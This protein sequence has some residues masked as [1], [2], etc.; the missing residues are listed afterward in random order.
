MNPLGPVEPD[1]IDTMVPPKIMRLTQ[2]MHNLI[3]IRYFYETLGQQPP[4]WTKLEMGRA[5]AALLSELD[6]EH[7]QG[8]AFRKEPTCD[9]KV[10]P[11]KT[12][13]RVGRRSPSPRLGIRRV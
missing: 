9:S 7:G 10:E 13:E 4:E 5:Q 8:G 12:E 11:T 6:R 2:H 3:Y 1:D